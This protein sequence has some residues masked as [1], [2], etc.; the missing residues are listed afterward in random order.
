MSEKFSIHL[1][2]WMVARERM[3]ATCGS[4]NCSRNKE[5]FKEASENLDKFIDEIKELSSTRFKETL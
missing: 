3:N 1:E 2:A 4:F 5:K